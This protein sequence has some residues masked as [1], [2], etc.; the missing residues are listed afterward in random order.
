MIEISRYIKD[1]PRLGRATLDVY[2]DGENETLVFDTRDD[3]Y[4]EY[5]RL[6]R[7]GAQLLPPELDGPL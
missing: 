7:D 1:D 4:R 5:I 6:C 2:I 3:A